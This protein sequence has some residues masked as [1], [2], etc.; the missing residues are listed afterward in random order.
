[1]VGVREGELLAAL[2]VCSGG[3]NASSYVQTAGTLAAFA[4]AAT[5]FLRKDVAA[6]LTAAEAAET[7]LGLLGD[8]VTAGPLDLTNEA[9]R[10][11]VG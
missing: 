4:E 1:V 5:P 2:A 3:S 6:C 10:M 7:D 11:E 8:V 9:P